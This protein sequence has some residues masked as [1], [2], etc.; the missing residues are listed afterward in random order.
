MNVYGELVS[1]QLESFASDP[2]TVLVEGRI[3]WNTLSKQAKVYNG[4][5]WT[6]LGSS[7][8]AGGAGIIWLPDES[9]D[10]PA[11]AIEIGGQPVW[12][13]QPGETQK[14]F[15]TVQVPSTY[16]SGQQ[17]K[18]RLKCF[19]PSTTGNFLMTTVA[20]LVRKD[21]DGFDSTTNQ[22]T[23]TNSAQSNGS[24]ANLNRTIEVDLTSSTG[25]IN[26]VA[27]SAG[28]SIKVQLSRGT[29][30]DTDN[31]RLVPLLTEVIISV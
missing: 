7:G 8:G 18:L 14:I 26:G 11:E 15:T 13:F 21:T 25:T 2:A 6:T 12:I 3:G 5:V 29:D 19:S 16:P 23:S 27:V 24:P 31:V 17:I 28:D 22:R 4:S 30:T 9:A 1:A 10:S 20:T